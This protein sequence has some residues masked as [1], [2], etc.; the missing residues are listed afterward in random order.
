MKKFDEMRL[1]LCNYFGGGVTFSNWEKQF[2]IFDTSITRTEEAAFDY[3]KKVKDVIKSVFEIVTIPETINF[4]INDIKNHVL[5]KCYDEEKIRDFLYICNQRG[6]DYAKEVEHFED[7][8]LF[9]LYK[10]LVYKVSQLV[11]NLT[12]EQYKDILHNSYVREKEFKSIFDSLPL[13]KIIIIKIIN[14]LF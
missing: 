2:G 4:T 6:I 7:Y 1:E 10:E 5:S 3:Y 14:T 13:D 12:D 8:E 9:E 11:N